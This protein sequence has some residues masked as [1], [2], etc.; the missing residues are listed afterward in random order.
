MWNSPAQPCLHQRKPRIR[1]PTL[2]CGRKAGPCRHVNSGPSVPSITVGSLVLLASH[3]LDWNVRQGPSKPWGSHRKS[4][5]EILRSRR[6]K[7]TTTQGHATEQRCGYRLIVCR[8][9]EHFRSRSCQP[10][11][12]HP[13]GLHFVRILEILKKTRFLSSSSLQSLVESESQL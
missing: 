4:E 9:D 10:S 2:P 6:E 8:S 7:Q 13:R 12:S 11:H 5:K 1:T 3:V